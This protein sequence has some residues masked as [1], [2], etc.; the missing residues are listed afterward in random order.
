MFTD[1]NFAFGASF[2]A[3]IGLGMFSSM[4]LLALYS[5]KLLGYDALTSGLVLAPGGLGNMFSLILC[6]RLVTR[7]DQRLLLTFGCLVNAIS[8]YMMSNLTLGDGLLEPD[9][10]AHHPGLR[11]RLHLRAARPP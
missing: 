7:V 6:G 1:R 8:L 2:I 5:Q 4:V 11:A 3:L 9:P 10:A